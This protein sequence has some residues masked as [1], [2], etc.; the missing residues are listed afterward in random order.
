MFKWAM[1]FLI[2]AIIAAFFGY[3]GIARQAADMARVV[4]YIALGLLVIS[5][6]INL[7]KM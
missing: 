1:L 4:F 2:I 5:V 6:G 3:T 7:V